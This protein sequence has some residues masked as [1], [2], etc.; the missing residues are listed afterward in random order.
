LSNSLIG[1]L[2][3][4][5]HPDAHL[6]VRREAGDAQTQR[7]TVEVEPRRRSFCVWQ[8]CLRHRVV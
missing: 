5:R 7:A 6:C 2:Q 4:R 3:R 1:F 8:R